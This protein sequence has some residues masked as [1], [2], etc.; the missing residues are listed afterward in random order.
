MKNVKLRD[1]YAAQ[2]LETHKMTRN[3]E[4]PRDFIDAYLNA[5]FEK[6]KKGE[7]TYFDGNHLV[8]ELYMILK[9]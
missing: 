1:D 7:H 9:L 4:H 5:M 2:Q 6:Q 8:I 3:P